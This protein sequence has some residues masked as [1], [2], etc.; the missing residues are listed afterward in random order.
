V[1]LMRQDLVKTREAAY[2]AASLLNVVRSAQLGTNGDGA[3]S[4]RILSEQDQ[5]DLFLKLVDEVTAYS[6]PTPI[7]NF[8]PEYD[9]ARSLAMVIRQMPNELK[10]YAADRAVSVD[11]KLDD[12]IG[13]TQQPLA[14]WQRYQAT[15][16]SAPVET[17]LDSVTEAPAQMRDYLYQQVASRIATSGDTA[18]ARQIISERVSNPAQR[19]VALQSLL[20]QE[21]NSAADKGRYEEAFRLLSKMPAGAERAAM[22]T[23][24]LDQ[25]GPGVKKQ[26]ALQYLVQGKNMITA[27]PRAEDQ[28]QMHS[29]L[30][31][32]RVFARYDVNQAFEIVEPLLEQFNEVSAAA[33]TMN[34]FDRNYYREGELITSNE[35]P[36]AQMANLFS[37]TLAECAMHDFDRAKTTAEGLNRLEVRIRAFLLIAQRTMDIPLE[38]EEPMGYNSNE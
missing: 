18:R 3:A 5:R 22:V 29:L 35:N 8:T 16:T 34:G 4:G 27:A 36:I 13:Q 6:A 2:L 33:V 11:K 31:L 17:A 26:L 19:Q 9:A 37:E 7:T 28:E 15:I 20:Q 30:V 24:I 10:A 23:T 1:K 12:L 25:L 38:P 32:A 14:D 21:V